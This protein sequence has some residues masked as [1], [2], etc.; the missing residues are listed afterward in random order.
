MRGF[1]LVLFMGRNNDYALADYGLVVS[2]EHEKGG[3]LAGAEEKSRGDFLL[4]QVG[5]QCQYLVKHT[6]RNY[7]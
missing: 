5:A 3:T 4:L 2:A 1:L 6:I 7:N